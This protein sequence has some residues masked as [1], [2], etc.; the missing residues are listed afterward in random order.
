MSATIA[1]ES[2]H[3]VPEPYTRLHIHAP[4]SALSIV[5]LAH[6]MLCQG[7]SSFGAAAFISTA[8][9]SYSSL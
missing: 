1:S 6:P 3:V 2:K 5:P 8:F 7:A 9:A 4:I